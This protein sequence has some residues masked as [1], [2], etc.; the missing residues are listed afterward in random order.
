[1]GGTPCGYFRPHPAW[2]WPACPATA[3]L[4]GTCGRTRRLGDFIAGSDV[5]SSIN[6]DVTDKKNLPKFL[7][8]A[9]DDIRYEIS[10]FQSDISFRPVS[11]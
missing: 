5:I 7:R 3:S 2:T 1:M 9:I 4:R 11:I 8:Q 6:Y 10:G